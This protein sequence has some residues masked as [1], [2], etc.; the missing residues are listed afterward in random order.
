MIEG[1]RTLPAQHLSIRVPWHDAGWTG[2]V[3]NNPAKNTACRILK[4]IAERKS[5]EEEVAV[6]GSSFSDLDAEKLPPCVAEKVGFMMPF[7]LTEVKRHPYIEPNPVTHGHFDRTR[8]TMKPFSAPCVPYRWMLLEE[9]ADLVEMY[10]LGFQPEREPELPFQNNWV[11]ERKNQ[12]V[13]LGTFFSAVRP[14]E[15]LC[16]FYAKDTPLSLKAARV[17]VAVGLVL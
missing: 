2:R 17:I 1:S 12:L 6:A 3:C 13:M 11:Q 4:R 14:A 7:G 15:S 9:A 8:Y 5:D 10:D 16:F